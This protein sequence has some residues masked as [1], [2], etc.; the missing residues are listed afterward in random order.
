M[1]LYNIKY[2]NFKIVQ[3]NLNQIFRKQ[4]FDNTT[5]RKLRGSFGV[6][7]I[8]V[9][10]SQNRV[11]VSIN[12]S[13]NN[14]RCYGMSI[15]QSN[16]PKSIEDYEIKT[17]IKYFFSTLSFNPIYLYAQTSSLKS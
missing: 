4:E 10:H 1:F 7:D 16:L 12:S 9:D 13:I 15:Y 5:Q 6:R 11:F 3:S 17:Q 8:F 2:N 14:N